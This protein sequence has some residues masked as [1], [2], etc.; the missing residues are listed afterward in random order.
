MLRCMIPIWGEYISSTRQ[1]TGTR[2]KEFYAFQLLN[3]SNIS[4]SVPMVKLCNYVE[5][6]VGPDK[7][8]NVNTL[9]GISS[10]DFGYWLLSLVCVRRLCVGD[11]RGA[12]H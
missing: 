2:H 9:N 3:N 11:I 12:I 4:K 1:E 8:N 6:I 7:Y 10:E 5:A